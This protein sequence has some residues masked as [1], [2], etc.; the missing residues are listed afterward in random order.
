MG[1]DPVPNKFGCTHASM[2]ACRVICVHIFWANHTSACAPRHIDSPSFKYDHYSALPS[3][4]KHVFVQ[5]RSCLQHGCRITHSL[6]ESATC[7]CSIVARAPGLIIEFLKL[8]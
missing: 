4:Q 1:N 6:W 7:L 8:I 2:Q 5:L 3:L